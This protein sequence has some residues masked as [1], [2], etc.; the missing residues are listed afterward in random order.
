MNGSCLYKSVILTE[1]THS[2]FVTFYGKD[3]KSKKMNQTQM[4]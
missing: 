4:F 3:E 1:I 2:K